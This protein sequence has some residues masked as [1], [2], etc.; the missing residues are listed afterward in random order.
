MCGRYA[1]FW[2]ATDLAA[3]FG[4]PFDTEQLAPHYNLAPMQ[5]APVIVCD[6]GLVRA[7]IMRWGL[8]SPWLG[9]PQGATHV[10][11]TQV[12]KIT[13]RP[14]FQEAFATHRAL[15]P[16]NGYF[17]WE[18][19]YYPWQRSAPGRH[20]YYITRGD[21]TPLAIAGLWEASN[22]SN[23]CSPAAFTLLTTRANHR[24]R[25]INDRMPV[26]LEPQHWSAWLSPETDPTTLL[27]LLKP[28]SP[29]ELTCR[30]VSQRIDN[31]HNDDASL[32]EPRDNASVR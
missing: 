22:A 19:T 28:Y 26:I 29:E 9:D 4:V 32:I 7:K 8:S 11:N 2:S 20:R 21:G 10:T 24:L 30:Q 16:M 25:T 23:N 12:E 31:L 3:H 15:V 17:E 18:Q 1:L 6:N 27:T 13:S 14:A 5:Y